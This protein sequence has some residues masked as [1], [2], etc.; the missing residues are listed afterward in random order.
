MHLADWRVYWFITERNN[1]QLDLATS[2]PNNCRTP[3]LQ[4]ALTR[5]C[6]FFIEK[7]TFTERDLERFVKKDLVVCIEEHN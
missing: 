7:I 6:I 4:I 3:L 1:I 2:D 5:A